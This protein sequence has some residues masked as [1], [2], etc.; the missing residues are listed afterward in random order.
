V[1]LASQRHSDELSVL[2]ISAA[3]RTRPLGARRLLRPAEHGAVAGGS[4][5]FSLTMTICSSYR[6]SQAEDAI[7]H[8]A[9]EPPTIGN[10][11]RMAKG[12][13][14]MMLGLRMH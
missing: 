5:L 10:L 11:S 6:S 8:A 4:S 1:D 13:Y 3:Y 14:R 9:Y 7:S 2:F 12:A